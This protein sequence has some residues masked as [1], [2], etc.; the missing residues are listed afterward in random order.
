MFINDENKYLLE[1]TMPYV[2]ETF[3]PSPDNDE[4][5]RQKELVKKGLIVHS[6]EFPDEYGL[7]VDG[8]QMLIDIY[9]SYRTDLRSILVNNKNKNSLCRIIST[10]HLKD[11]LKLNSIE[12]FLSNGWIRYFIQMLTRE[13]FFG[14]AATMFTEGFSE[15]YYFYS[16]NDEIKYLAE[17]EAKKNS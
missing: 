14:E 15:M 17:R 12:D 9:S 16:K 8:Y 11:G 10:K 3:V 6:E 2:D 4:I 5:D 13:G 7:S 1:Y